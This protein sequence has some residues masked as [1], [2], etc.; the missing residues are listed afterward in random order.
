MCARMKRAPCRARMI[1]SKYAKC[2]G[3]DAW[4]EQALAHIRACDTHLECVIGRPG[5]NGEVVRV[6][7]PL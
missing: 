1:V 7:L 3:K 2:A 4:V 5:G 6:D